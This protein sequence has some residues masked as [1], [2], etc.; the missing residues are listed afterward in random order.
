MDAVPKLL[1]HV[2]QCRA[3]LV[4]VMLFPENVSTPAVALLTILAISTLVRTTPANKILNLPMT[5]SAAPRVAAQLE[6]SRL[7]RQVFV[8]KVTHVTLSLVMKALDPAKVRLFQTTIL[9]TTV[10]PIYVILQLD[11][12]Y[13]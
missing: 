5:N 12:L 8:L 2:L 13:L 3:P 4:F 7:Y 9:P 11:G 6:Q 10:I 1:T